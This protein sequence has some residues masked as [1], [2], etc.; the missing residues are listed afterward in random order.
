MLFF[1]VLGGE[2]SAVV[3]VYAFGYACMLGVC[4]VLCICLY[5]GYVYAGVGVRVFCWGAMFSSLYISSLAISSISVEMINC[6]QT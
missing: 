5:A 4:F 3:S 1:G 6:T 2:V